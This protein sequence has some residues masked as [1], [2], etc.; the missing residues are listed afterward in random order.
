M[1]MELFTLRT[2]VT[3]SL[4]NTDQRRYDA[5]DNYNNVQ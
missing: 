4:V 1:S 3:T 5:S 2:K